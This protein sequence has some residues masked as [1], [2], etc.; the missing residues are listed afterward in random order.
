MYPNRDIAALINKATYLYLRSI[1]EPSDNQLEVLVE[2]A[3][4]NEGKQGKIDRSNQLPELAA[5][6]KDSAPIESIHGCATYRLYWKC[7]VAYLVTEE[8]VG[9]CGR[10]DDE[11][12]EGR[13]FRLYTKSHFLDHLSRD[14]G[15]HS[16]P[17][18]HYKITC[19]NHLVDVAA[20]DPPEIEIASRLD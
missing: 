5:L 3:V 4:V 1:Q 10:Y 14:T 12:C 6:L 15:A 20:E 7:Y 11:S 2:E 13:L 8:C 9:S 17:L 19:L 18:L 16:N